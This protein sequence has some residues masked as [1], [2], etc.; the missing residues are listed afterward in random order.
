MNFY[1]LQL[2]YNP[3]TFAKLSKCGE[4]VDTV[5]LE[6]DITNKE[7]FLIESA[8]NQII[9]TLKFPNYDTVFKN[10]LNRIIDNDFKD[11]LERY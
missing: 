7:L 10:I 5:Y 6:L 4:F 2:K 11:Y 9:Q 8:D 1:E 3:Y